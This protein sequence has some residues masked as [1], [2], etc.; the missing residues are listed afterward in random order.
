MATNP[1]NSVCSRPPVYVV[2]GCRTPFIKSR[3]TPGPFTAT[4]LA[5]AAARPLFNRLPLQPSMLDEVI[6]GCVIPGPD[7]ANIARIT[8]LRL[9]CGH[10]VLGWTVQR[11]C[12]SGMQAIDSACKDIQ[13]GRANLVLAGGVEAMS[14]APLLLKTD[15][16]RWLAAWQRSKSPWARA[17]MLR[18]L[19]PT[20]FAPI[21]ALLRGLRDPVVGLSMGVT[22]EI[23]AEH[24]NISRN[25]MDA[26]AMRSHQR[27]AAAQE[28]GQLEEITPVYATSGQ[29]WC[30]DDGVRPDSSMESLARLSPVFERPSGLVTAGNSSQVS[31]GA[32]TLL[33]A[34]EAA[35]EQH[36]LPVLGRIEGCMWAGLEPELMGLG[37]IYSST[38]LLQQHNMQL[39]DVDY[40]E[41]NEAFAVQVEACLSACSS[42]DWCRDHLGM[43]EAAGTIDPE[44]LNVDGGS[45]AIGH[46]VGAT[47]AR[48]VLHLL[49]VLRR[50]QA[51]RGIASLC[52][53]GGQGGS[54]MVVCDD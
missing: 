48:I 42:A 27:M 53:G 23:L 49:H 44:R 17:N 28:A 24:F 37:P 46:P 8:A 11:N 15:M 43:P 50:K 41:I 31:D 1:R 39:E 7:E 9:G 25:S 51:R 34:S 12:A 5:L 30:E 22:A 18:H 36:Q 20:M 35:V 21:I 3:N 45:I 10:H 32:A 29:V 4:E 16:V 52:I 33:L 6:L 14:H 2:D 19:R 26:F 47:G 40:W 13:S 54:I 38:K